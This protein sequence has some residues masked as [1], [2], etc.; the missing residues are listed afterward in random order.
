MESSGPHLAAS[1]IGPCRQAVASGRRKT[2]SGFLCFIKNWLLDRMTNQS[3]MLVGD[4]SLSGDNDW[5]IPSTMEKTDL[6][7]WNYPPA[8]TSSS[9]SPLSAST[10][11]QPTSVLMGP[12][13]PG[14]P[15][16]LLAPPEPF[17]SLD[18]AGSLVRMIPTLCVQSTTFSHPFQCPAPPTPPSFS[19]WG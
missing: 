18:P 6:Q 12:P 5:P 4:M 9:P 11:L 8:T 16:S 14:L 17:F 3:D 19:G 2:Q 15:S 1:G 7:L 13:G 10:P